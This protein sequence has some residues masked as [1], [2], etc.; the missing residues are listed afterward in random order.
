MA[1]L[2]DDI[3]EEL[4]GSDP[5]NILS[6]DYV[7]PK[8]EIVEVNDK[9]PAAPKVTLVTGYG[10]QQMDPVDFE[11]PTIE[12]LFGKDVVPNELP[13][14]KAE[15]VLLENGTN[16]LLDS[17]EIQSG[18]INARAISQEDIK[19]VEAVMPGYLNDHEHIGFYT[20]TPTLTRYAQAVTKIASN[21]D[22]QKSK[23]TELFLQ[24]SEGVKESIKK[25]AD[26]LHTSLINNMSSRLSLREKIVNQLEGFDFKGKEGEKLFNTFYG[27]LDGSLDQEY[28][29]ALVVVPGLMENAR[30]VLN[31]P[32]I[33]NQILYTFIT[34]NSSLDQDSLSKLITVNYAVFD[35]KD[36][37]SIKDLLEYIGSSSESNLASNLKSILNAGDDKVSKAIEDVKELSKDKTYDMGSFNKHASIST[38]TYDTTKRI[39]ELVKDINEFDKL[40]LQIGS[41]LI[42]NINSIV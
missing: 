30:T 22:N 39:N 38:E 42:K 27:M 12:D 8:E 36:D 20:K 26:F 7:I 31:K 34:K 25:T 4:A 10:Q 5:N 23:Q 40:I 28:S 33:L 29:S 32:S 2:N 41:E 24:T 16:A 35:K 14:L 11:P 9:Q 13:N 6:K 19:N 15:F 21:I 37:Y 18:I 3:E 17:R 1:G